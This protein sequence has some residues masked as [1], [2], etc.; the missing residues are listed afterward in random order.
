ML[1]RLTHITHSRIQRGRGW[2]GVGGSGPP[3][4]PEKSQKIGFLNNSGHDQLENHKATKSAFNVWQSSAHQR[5]AISMAFC[6]RADNGPL[7]VVI[8]SS[9]SPSAK[10]KKKKRCQSWTPSDKIFS[11]RA[12]D[13]TE[14]VA[15][16]SP[17]S[18][19]YITS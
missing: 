5:N 16:E 10:K 1:Q 4:P 7:I 11:I 15:A 19:V 6:W 14:I 9:F 2:G 18:S 17:I 13:N 3:P 8:G 12:C